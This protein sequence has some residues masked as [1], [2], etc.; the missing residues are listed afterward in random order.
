MHSP[1]H[2]ESTPDTFFEQR[3]DK[4]PVQA[5]LKLGSTSSD[6]SLFY[7]SAQVS[8]PH[9]PLNQTQPPEADNSLV[10]APGTEPA[11]GNSECQ[12]YVEK[13]L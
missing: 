2:P 7:P 4:K 8:L 3:M 9:L 13:V 6:P 11:P 12:K 10:G 5:A 1:R